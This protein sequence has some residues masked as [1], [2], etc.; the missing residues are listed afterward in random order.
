MKGFSGLS[1]PVH[2]LILKILFHNPEN[3]VSDCGGG[4]LNGRTV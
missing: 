3:P 1:H 2:P 4:K